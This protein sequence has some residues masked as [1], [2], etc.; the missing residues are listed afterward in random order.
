MRSTGASL[1]SPFFYPLS[2]DGGTTRSRLRSTGRLDLGDS[3]EL[4]DGDVNAI[5]D[6]VDLDRS[7]LLDRDEIRA[8]L[9]DVSDLKRGHR[10]VSDD[11][12][13]SAFARLDADDSGEV[14]CDELAAFLRRAGKRHA[15]GELLRT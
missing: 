9:A 4:S 2:E 12:I 10:N 14:D 13:A 11:E 1:L 3:D 7:G 6:R 15:W 5:F 8:F